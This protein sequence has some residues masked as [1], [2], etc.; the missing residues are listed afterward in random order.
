MFFFK[1]RR[2]VGF[3]FPLGRRV[4]CLWSF[5]R[6]L[7]LTSPAV[8]RRRNSSRP[9]AAPLTRRARRA[10]RARPVV[11]SW[12]A[13]WRTS[14]KTRTDL[15][16]APRP[17]SAEANDALERSQ[18]TSSQEA[19]NGVDFKYIYIKGRVV[20]EVSTAI[21]TVVIPH[22]QPCPPVST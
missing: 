6:H 9:S 12:W 14:A 22:A 8:P 5:P 20:G 2:S 15:S 3:F 21:S 1:L 7:S 16:P 11:S 19:H 10:R 17:P 13:A 4:R 18:W